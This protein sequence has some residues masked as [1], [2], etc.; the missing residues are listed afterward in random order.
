MISMKRTVSKRLINLSL[1]LIIL[2]PMMIY[3]Q[4]DC[5]TIDKFG[6][7]IF[8]MAEESMRQRFPE[9]RRSLP[10]LSEYT[11]REITTIM[12][13]MGNNYYWKHDKPIVPSKVGVLIL[14][15]GVNGP[16]D[17]LLYESMRPLAQQH[18]TSIAY[19]MSMM[20]SDHISCALQEIQQ[21]GVE[22][23]YVVPLSES[24]YNTLI[25]QWRYA[26]DLEENYS[27]A[28]ISQIKSDNI[29]FLS[30]INDHHFAREIVYDFAMQVSTNPA[31]ETVVLVAHGP[32]DHADNSKQIRLMTNILEHVQRKGH[33]YDVIPLSLQD[34]A[35]PK[36]RADNVKRLRETI[37]V[38]TANNRR[39][40]IVTNLMSSDV[41]QARVERD[42]EG[43]TYTFNTSGLVEHPYF[44]DWISETINDQKARD[45]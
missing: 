9:I 26:F 12:R 42:L 33:F 40:L 37:E 7:A 30:T 38:N 24:P 17:Q 41:I 21:E 36:V 39:V 25:G 2:S 11:D 43:L 3:S 14:A 32:I 18:S 15:H 19:G 34:D 10:T 1:L 22:R 20:T 27:F 35:S 8:P 16:G 13:S 6:K 29:K 45:D 44:V 4:T 23:V 31:E 5:P 28:D